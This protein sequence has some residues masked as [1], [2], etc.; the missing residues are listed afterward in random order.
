[1][2]SELE[3][4]RRLSWANGGFLG[5]KRGGWIH[6]PLLNYGDKYIYVRAH[7]LG[8]HAVSVL[9]L[10]CPYKY[11]HVSSVSFYLYLQ[12]AFRCYQSCLVMRF[13]SE[14]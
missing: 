11:L 4:V 14:R 5:V 13:V 6:C 2:V 12:A 9:Y 10:Q 7:P 8:R 1:M 3:S